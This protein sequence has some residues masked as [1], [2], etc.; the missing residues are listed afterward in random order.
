MAIYTRHGAEVEI[1]GT[2]KKW[3]ERGCYLV[4]A[5]QKT[6]YPDGSGKDRI[7]KSAFSEDC[8]SEGFASSKDF[9]ADDGI[10]EIYDTC[11]KAPD[12]S[13]TES[14]IPWIM[15]YYWPHMFDKKGKPIYER[16]KAS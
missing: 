12:L 16:V 11:A 9:V 5:I 7:G 8:K 3:A 13:P 10:R 14:R 15:N 2:Y 6:A 1:V 4:K